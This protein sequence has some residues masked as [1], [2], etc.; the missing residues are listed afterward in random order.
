[1]GFLL[2]RMRKMGF[3]LPRMRKM[4]FPVANDA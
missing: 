4:G 2:P 3:L 1:M